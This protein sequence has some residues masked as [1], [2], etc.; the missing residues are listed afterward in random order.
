MTRWARGVAPAL[1]ERDS[2]LDALDEALRGA[3]AGAGSL[4][5]VQGPGGIGKT[6]LLTEIRRRADAEGLSVLRARAQE[7]EREFGFGVVRQLFEPVLARASPE[8]RAQLLDG[9]AAPA[10]RPL[11][12]LA[13]PAEE[14]SDTGEPF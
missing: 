1:L 12:L 2:E 8:Q 10:P 7:L 6:A 4:V 13:A 3:S 9:A 14:P 5:L 11:G